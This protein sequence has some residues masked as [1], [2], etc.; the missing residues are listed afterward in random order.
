LTKFKRVFVSNANF[1]F[2]TAHLNQ[3]ADQVV[4][5]ADSPVFDDMIADP[6]AI[7]R[8]QTSVMDKLRDY[9]PKTDVLAF[10]GDVFLLA[11][12]LWEISQMELDH[13]VSIARWSAKAERY[14][15]LQLEV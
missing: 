11:M 1:R 2:G 13:P 14:L 15:V 7:D 6:V 12:A 9:D 10:Y 4:Y 3:L 5:L 8:F